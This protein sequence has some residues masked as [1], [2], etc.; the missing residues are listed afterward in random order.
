MDTDGSGF[1]SQSELVAGLKSLGFTNPD[2]IDKVRAAGVAKTRVRGGHAA[3]LCAGDAAACWCTITPHPP[4]PAEGD[5]G[6]GPRQQGQ[7]AGVRGRHLRPD[8]PE[9]AE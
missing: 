2:V 9:V 3:R 6:C 4:A 8:H 1:I 5:H 7:L